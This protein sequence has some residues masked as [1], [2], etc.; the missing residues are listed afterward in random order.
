M[1]AEKGI[2]SVE[3]LILVVLIRMATHAS[4]PYVSWNI[5]EFPGGLQS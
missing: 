5:K 2:I 3:L 4:I 1:A